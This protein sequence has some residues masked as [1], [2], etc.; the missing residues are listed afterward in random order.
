MACF[1]QYL[2]GMSRFRLSSRLAVVLALAA[3]LLAG[4]VAAQDTGGPETAGRVGSLFGD[5]A[6]LLLPDLAPTA[7]NPAPVAT[8]P[9]RFFPAAG[10]VVLLE[11]LPWAFN[12]YV[13]KESFAYIS[14][15]TIK[16]NFRTGFKYDRDDFVVNQSSHP[17][18]GGLFFDSARSNGYGYWESGLFALT[19]SLIWECCMENTAP[20]IN[21]LVNT[22]LGGMVRGEVA[23]RMSVLILDNTATGADRVWR[24]AAA[25]VINPV[26]AFN[27]L[28]RGEMT[29]SRPNPEDRFPSGFGLSVDGGYRRIAGSGERQDQGF[30]S[31]SALYGNPFAGDIRH[32]FD[33]FWVGLD[34]NAP[35]GT[36]F[37][38]IEERGILK[39]WELTETDS[40]ARHIFGFSQEYEYLNNKSQIFGAQMFGAG[41]LSRYQ[42]GKGLAVL[43]D[44]SAI[45]FPLAGIKTK[46]FQNPQ[47][48]YDYAP[49]GGLRAEGRLY[50]GTREVLGAGYGIAWATT[51]NGA[52][53]SNTLQFFRATARLPLPA[54]VSVG[55]AYAWYAR[56]TTYTG[57]SEPKRTQNEGRVF[58]NWVFPSR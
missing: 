32:P 58:V 46:D 48:G 12:R 30:V 47:S 17:F 49:G 53:N 55:A 13:T 35:R 8:A 14:S 2:P 4:P 18:H 19:G 27:R 21:D 16:A 26:G 20:S 43:T 42:V 54:P 28:L 23:H 57:F 51:A 25:A 40:A 1:S 5:R 56:K 44:F 33:T 45:A 6:G 11:V 38:R 7:E 29:H 41:V 39:A 24:E 52:S 3:A 36:F 31:L 9:K 10:E 50:V 37:S 15:A 22:T 34:I